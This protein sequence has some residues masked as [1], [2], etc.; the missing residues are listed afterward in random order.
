MADWF[1]KSNL[2]R[3]KSGTRGFLRSLITNLISEI[4]YGESNGRLSCEKW[5]NLNESSY[6]SVFE[7]ADYRSLES[8]NQSC[9]FQNCNKQLKTYEYLQSFIKIRSLFANRYIIL[10]SLFWILKIWCQIHNKQPRKSPN[11]F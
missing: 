9:K 6:S 5:F 8:E 11:K 4:Q 1:A 3:M 7:I 2:I 10:N